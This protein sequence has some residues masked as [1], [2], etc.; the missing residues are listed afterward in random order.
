METWSALGL[1]NALVR[2]ARSLASMASLSSQLVLMTGG[3]VESEAFW[4]R[5]CT[6]GWWHSLLSC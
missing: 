4:K 2:A 5:N 3:F 6:S 1:D